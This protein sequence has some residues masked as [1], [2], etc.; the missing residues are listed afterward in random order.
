MCP[1]FGGLRVLARINGAQVCLVT[2]KGCLYGLTFVSQF[3][4]ARKSVLSVEITDK[5]LSVGS[6]DTDIKKALE[7]IAEDKSVRVIPVVSLCVA[8]TAGFAAEL[9]PKKI[10]DVEIFPVKLPAY[11]L[12]S[13]PEAKDVAVLALL[14][15][16]ADFSVKRK[17]TLLIVGEI[18]P[19]DAMAI[20][21]LLQQLG[22]E[23]VFTLPS[24]SLDDY[25]EAGSVGACA[26]LHPFYEQ[27]A[28]F[29]QEKGVP[30]ITGNPV[31]ANSTYKWIKDIG[32]VLALNPAQVEL[33]AQQEKDKIKAVMQQ[34]KVEGSVIVAGYEGNEFPLVRLLL[35]AGLTVPYASTSIKQTPLGEEDDKLLKMLGTDVRYRKFLE[36]DRRAVLEHKPD[37]VIGT[38][39]LDS[40]V[41]E[42]GIPAVYYTNIMSSRPLYFAQGAATV[43][44]LIN[45]LL[46]RKNIYEKMQAFFQ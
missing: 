11:Q 5:T 32:E 45:G 15:R 1:G 31:G 42:M 41:K 2:D 10:G 3:Y 8:E 38:T 12:R 28:A 9:L 6:L 19:L 33:V 22:V 23:A 24:Q 44:T 39:S 36:E 27:T 29:F 17:K 21:A 16:F 34:H 25:K 26:I 46:K 40:Y 7:K 37:L 35:E 14:S 20:G 30:I 43:L 4:A 18:F 13:H